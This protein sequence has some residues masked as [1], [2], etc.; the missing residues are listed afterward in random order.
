MRRI[1]SARENV[2]RRR[3]HHGSEHESALTPDG[4]RDCR[5]SAGKPRA[6]HHRNPGR[7][8]T[9]EHLEIAIRRGGATA[10][11]SSWPRPPRVGVT[12]RVTATRDC[13]KE[14]TF[15]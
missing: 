2:L 3:N 10:A 4:S 9:S 1:A 6:L 13:F 7:F 8:T 11:R 14:D 5:K 12:R 15:S